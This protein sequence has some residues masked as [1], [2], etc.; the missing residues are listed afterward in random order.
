M[1]TSVEIAE[2]VSESI[3]AIIII[4]SGIVLLFFGGKLLKWI[5]FINGFLAV[6]DTKSDNED[7][8]LF[9]WIGNIPSNARIGQILGALNDQGYKACN[10]LMIKKG[11]NKTQ[12]TVLKVSDLQ[13]KQR[14]IKYGIKFG[15]S[16]NVT[17]LN[18]K[19]YLSNIKNTQKESWGQT[20]TGRGRGRGRGRGA[21]TDRGRGSRKN[22]LSSIGRSKT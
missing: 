12:W 19:D 13:T 18:V 4:I 10:K 14:A 16:P 17:N 22:K 21:N 8:N 3:L 20:N 9:V 5:V 7:D 6:E 1:T 11:V 2:E 15:K